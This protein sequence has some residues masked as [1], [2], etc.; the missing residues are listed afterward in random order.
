MNKYAKIKANALRFFLVISMCSI[1]FYLGFL[2]GYDNWIGFRPPLGIFNQLKGHSKSV[3]FSRFWQVWNTIQDKY[4]GETDNQKMLNGAISGMVSSLDDPYTMFMPSELNSQFREDLSG[5][6]DGI[7]AEVSSKDGSIIIVA[8]LEGSPAKKSGLLPQDIV[9]KIDGKS[10][11]GMTVEQAVAKIRGK[12]GTEVK[13]TITR[14]GLDQ[15]K[16]IK[17][18][19]NTIKIES[20]KWEMKEGDIAYIKV[21]QFGE[22]TM[23]LMEKAIDNIKAKNAKAV[24]VDMR[25]NPG[26]LLDVA[27]DMTSMFIKNGVV[28]QRK[29]KDGHIEKDYTTLS[30]NISKTKLYVLIDGGSASA[31]EIFAGAIQ[32]SKRGTLIG[33]KTFGKGSV[34]DL[35]ELADG[36]SIKV[37]IAKWLT[38]KGREI[39]KKGIEPD[40]EVKASDDENKD[41]VLDRALEEA[42][43]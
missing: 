43:K 27:I 1:F 8:P 32:D 23:G 17:V 3:D 31:S 4:A 28:V 36:S 30:Q 35:T 34:Q 22:D 33:E 21:T 6:F 10:T 19:R 7:G 2:V 39:D 14:E 20:V 41:A 24:I 13:L 38:P 29:Y 12:K 25:S 15:P 9:L 16:E 40:I 26:G 37:T 11:E 5:H 18:T 42:K